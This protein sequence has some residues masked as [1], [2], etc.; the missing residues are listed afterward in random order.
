VSV[1]EWQ[2][3]ISADGRSLVKPD[4]SPFFWLGHTAWD[5]FVRLERED[6]EEYLTLRSQQGFTVIQAGR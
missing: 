4:G 5:L 2:L 3:E 1:C 6:T